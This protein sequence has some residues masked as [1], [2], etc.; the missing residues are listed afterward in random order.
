MSGGRRSSATAVRTV[1]FNRELLDRPCIGTWIS[2]Q[3][4]Q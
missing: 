4:A 1:F 3:E 2:R